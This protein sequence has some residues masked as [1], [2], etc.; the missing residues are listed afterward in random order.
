MFG[1]EL[2]VRTER[3]KLRF[4]LRVHGEM[5]PFMA[6]APLVFT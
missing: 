2:L 1:D 3:A 4:A 5:F 6:A